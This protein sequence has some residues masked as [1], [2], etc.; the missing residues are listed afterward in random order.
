MYQIDEVSISEESICEK[1]VGV[2]PLHLL[3][4]LFFRSQSL[5]L[6]IWPIFAVNRLNWQCCL[7]ASSKTAPRIFDFFKFPWVPIIQ[8]S[9]FPLRPMCPNLL[10]IIKFSQAV[11]TV[12]WWYCST[13]EH[14]WLFCM[15]CRRIFDEDFSTFGLVLMERGK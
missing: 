9:L 14:P 8:L 2:T 1:L 11:C 12:D 4:S 5:G 6:Y 13:V 3:F 15:V 7:A 10:H